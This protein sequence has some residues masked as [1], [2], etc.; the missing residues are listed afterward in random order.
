MQDG[1]YSLGLLE[2]AV[3]MFQPDH[4][5]QS[6]LQHSYQNSRGMIKCAV[7]HEYDVHIYYQTNLMVATSLW[8]HAQ[9]LLHIHSYE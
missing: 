4:I 6:L 7:E 9:F 2:S 1:L 5:V 8:L 3:V